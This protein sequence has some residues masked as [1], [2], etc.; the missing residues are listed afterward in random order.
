MAR[1]IARAARSAGRGGLTDA[2]AFTRANW[3]TEG[4]GR[5]G[6]GPRAYR[7]DPSSGTVSVDATAVRKFALVGVPLAAGEVYEVAL[8]IRSEKPGAVI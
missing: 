5:G 2:A 3:Y 8:R 7:F 6:Q 1:G 4:Y